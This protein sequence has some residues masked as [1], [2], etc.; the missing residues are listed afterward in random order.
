LRR[1][2]ADLIAASSPSYCGILPQ[3]RRHL[4]LD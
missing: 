1:V 2:I 3:L 4:Q